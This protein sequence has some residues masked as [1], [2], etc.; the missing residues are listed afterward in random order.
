Y[1]YVDLIETNRRR[2]KQ[3][4][5]YEL[6]DTGIFDQDRY[7]DVFVEYA[8]GRP[9]D[10]LIRVTIHN[11]GPD[12][13][14]LHVLPTIWFRNEWSWGTTRTRPEMRRTGAGVVE[15]VHEAFGTRHL[16]CEGDPDLLFTENETN[17][18]RIFGIPNLTPFVKDAIDNYIVHDQK[19]AINPAQ[20]GTKT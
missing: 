3:D 18:Q 7:F 6:I 16:F 9:E 2:G 8:K 5:E 11:R 19:G 13:A 15:I 12:A 14:I 20:V 1:P 17:T 10:I 4:F